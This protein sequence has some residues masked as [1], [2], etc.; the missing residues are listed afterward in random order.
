MGLH[1]RERSGAVCL[2]LK[3]IGEAKDS[4]AIELCETHTQVILNF[5]IKRD[6]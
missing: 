5:H 2:F 6:R 3:D 4:F 1:R